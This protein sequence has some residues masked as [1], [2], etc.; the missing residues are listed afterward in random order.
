MQGNPTDRFFQHENGDPAEA[1]F[2]WTGGPVEVAER[3]WFASV[4][5]GATAFETAEGVVLVDTGTKYFGPQIAE[6]IRQRTDEP[7]TH[8]IYTHGHVDHAYGTAHWLRDGQGP[9]EVYAHEAMADRFGRY[10]RTPR[11][12][13][14]INMRQFG[15]T[16]IGA[17]PEADQALDTFEAPSHPPTVTYGQPTELAV[18]GLTF[19]LHPARGETDDATWVFCPQRGVLCT[20]DLISWALPNGGNPQKAQRYPWDWAEALREMAACRPR[21]LAPGHGGP[22]VDDADLVQR[23]LVTTAEVLER[24]TEQTI[25]ALEDGSPPHVDLVHAVDVT[26]PDLPWLVPMYDDPEFLVRNIIRWF[27]G[28]WTGRPSELKPAPR[29]DVAVEVVGLAGGVTAVLERM[30]VLVED[31]HLGLA[32]HLADWALEAE[33]AHRAVQ[34]AVA[35]L[36]DDSADTEPSLM[37]TNLFRSAAAYARAGRPFA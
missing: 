14:M 36:Y 22:V 4:F 31:G 25:A 24:L 34:A 17:D 6:R 30:A 7:V 8:V 1:G 16:G 35:S 3:T 11:H 10:A 37:A 23:I 27:G 33:P 29:H 13:S 20:G 12:N 21:S 2:F 28:W 15:G 18:G 5:S 9:P 32:R 26:L 19:E